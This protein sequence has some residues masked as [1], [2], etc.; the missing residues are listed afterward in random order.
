[1]TT[2]QRLAI[3]SVIVL[4]AGLLGIEPVKP[5]KSVM[6]KDTPQF[7][8]MKAPI[9]S[10]VWSASDTGISA[11]GN[12]LTIPS[13][14]SGLS[15]P[16]MDT[17]RVSSNYIVGSVKG[18]QAHSISMS[19]SSDDIDYVLAFFEEKQMEQIIYDI[20]LYLLNHPRYDGQLYDGPDG[21]GNHA[22]IYRIQ[23][24]ENNFGYAIFWR[25]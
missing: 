3:G 1:M 2:K 22:V 19:T 17:R 12:I 20:R 8:T 14:K 16:V 25:D 24:G 6:A 9:L 21:Y 23:K 13:G 5:Y 15:V 10:P 11:I 18:N 4:L 7:I